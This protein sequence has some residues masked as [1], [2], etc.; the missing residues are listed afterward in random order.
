MKRALSAVPK[1]TNAELRHPRIERGA[2][3]GV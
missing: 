1:V 3:A 2:L